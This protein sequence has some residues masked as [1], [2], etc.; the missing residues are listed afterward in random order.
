M[1][2]FPATSLSK[3]ANIER[4]IG[5]SA[6]KKIRSDN[7]FQRFIKK[8][9]QDTSPKAE[10]NTSKAPPQYEPKQRETTKDSKPP[11]PKVNDTKGQRSILEVEGY[12]YEKIVFPHGL[13]L[14]R[15]PVQEVKEQEKT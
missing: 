11:L 6:F 1:V 4:Q 9:F 10:E 2:F 14:K 8:K 7:H 12:T 5:D 15:I 13:I 3:S